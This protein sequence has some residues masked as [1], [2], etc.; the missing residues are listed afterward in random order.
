[1]DVSAL[2]KKE[3]NM[4]KSKIKDIGLDVA[5]EDIFEDFTGGKD[6]RLFCYRVVWFLKFWYY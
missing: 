3:N 6:F 1:M 4:K 5:K 2:R